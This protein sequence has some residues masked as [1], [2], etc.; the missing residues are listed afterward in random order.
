M[1][2]VIYVETSEDG[3][4]SSE[5]MVQMITNL[6][7]TQY[8]PYVLFVN[9]LLHTKYVKKLHQM[10]VPVFIC[11]DSIYTKSH[12][13]RRFNLHLLKIVARLAPVLYIPLSKYLHR[14]AIHTLTDIVTREDINII[15]LNISTSRDLFGIFVA[16]KYNIP[17]VSHIRSA[18]MLSFP[19]PAQKLANEHVSIFIAISNFVKDVWT[20]LGINPKKIII[21]LNGIDPLS[22]DKKDYSDIPVKKKLTFCTVGRL[23]E[24]KNHSWLLASF[25][26]YLSHRSDAQLLI[27]GDGPERNKLEQLV[28]SYNIEQSV[29]FAGT[30]ENPDILMKDADIFVF[31]SRKEPFGRA[32]LEAMS[33]GMPSIASDSGGI[34]EFITHNINGLLV[35]LNDIPG[36]TNAMIHLSTHGELATRLGTQ[37]QKNARE[38]F[39]SAQTTHKVEKIYK[40]IT[41]SQLE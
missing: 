1:K 12:A 28:R 32:V 27:I 26:N 14:S 34:P 21:I 36:L 30:V 35:P 41:S 40:E 4:G 2:R 13:F 11:H 22:A 3:G 23:V 7:Q 10:G 20:E 38:Q 24:W 25:R 17:C 29:T 37:A 8:K 31:P 6:D 16:Q 33:L 9:D 18:K 5:S 15:H 39:N 19:A